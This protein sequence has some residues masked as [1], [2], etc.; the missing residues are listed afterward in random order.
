V[1]ARE[2]DP[3]CMYAL[4]V[5]VCTRIMHACWHESRTFYVYMCPC[6][7]AC[8]HVSKGLHIHKHAYINIQPVILCIHIR[9]FKTGETDSGHCTAFQYRLFD[10]IHIYTHIHNHAY[11]NMQPVILCIH[12]R[13]F[14]T[15]ETDSR[16][17]TALQHR[18]FDN[19]HIYTH[20]QNVHTY[21]QYLGFSWVHIWAVKTEKKNSRHCTALRRAMQLVGDGISKCFC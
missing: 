1:L 5:C 17:C 6:I 9:T 19:I 12:I 3:L 2:S 7:N 16:H 8:A 10:N 13:T 21:M 20:I 11:M 15:G 18:L 4:C 14:K